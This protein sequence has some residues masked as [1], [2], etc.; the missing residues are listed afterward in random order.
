MQRP[1]A[2]Y[3]APSGDVMVPPELARIV[4]E[5]RGGLRDFRMIHRG[6]RADLDNLL[7]ALRVAGERWAGADRGSPRAEQAEADRQWY[8]TTQAASATGYSDRWIRQLLT[9]EVI[10]AM[11]IGGHR[12]ISR[13]Q[14]RM[15]QRRRA[16]GS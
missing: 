7:E 11:W 15:L 8:T 12:V 9:D 3:I 4:Y 5:Q 1:P 13:D 16:G 10:E 14:V 6:K 2:G